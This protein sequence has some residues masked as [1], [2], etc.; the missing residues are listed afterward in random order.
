MSVQSLQTPRRQIGLPISKA[1]VPQIMAAQNV[2][3]RE[4]AD[5]PIR[6]HG[7]PM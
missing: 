4:M 6:A 1:L 7:C 3:Q 5:N 2:N